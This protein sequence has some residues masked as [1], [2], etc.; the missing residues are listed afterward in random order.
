EICAGQVGVGVVSMEEFRER[1]AG[2]LEGHTMKE[3]AA[4]FPMLADSPV[5][6]PA[7]FCPPGGESEED[8]ARRVFAGLTRL[9][10]TYCREETVLL[11]CHGYTCREI[12]RL[13]TGTPREALYDFQPP[14]CR[15]LEY[16]APRLRAPR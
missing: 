2:E 11:V 4:R 7:G 10:R 3:A 12:H 13:L 16:E 9:L 1:C 6:Y 5:M 15:L 8:V 14:N